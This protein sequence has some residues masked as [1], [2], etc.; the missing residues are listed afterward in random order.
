MGN[1]IGSC[2]LVDNVNVIAPFLSV[3][4]VLSLLLFFVLL[5]MF[6]VKICLLYWLPGGCEGRITKVIWL[7][8]MT[9]LV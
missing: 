1:W 8:V 2:G 4:S 3:Y 7:A 6:T 5:P 9:D